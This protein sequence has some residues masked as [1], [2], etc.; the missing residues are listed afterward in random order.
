MSRTTTPGYLAGALDKEEGKKRFFSFDPHTMEYA[1]YKAGFDEA[2]EL[3]CYDPGEYRPWDYY[4]DHDYRPGCDCFYC[5][6][7]DQ[8]DEHEVGC[9]CFYC[10]PE[11]E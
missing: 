11:P 9:N 7:P 6:V 10:T 1:D 2:E 8:R 3:S 4:R 5:S